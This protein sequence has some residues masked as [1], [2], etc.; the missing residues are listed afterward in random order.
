L[1]LLLGLGIAVTAHCLTNPY[2]HVELTKTMMISFLVLIV[3]LVSSL[4]VVPLCK[5][6]STKSFG[7]LLLGTYLVTMTVEVLVELGIIWK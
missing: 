4:I 1:N 7:G 6:K 2:L 3:V 5:F